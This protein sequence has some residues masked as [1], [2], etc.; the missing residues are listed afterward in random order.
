MFGQPDTTMGATPALDPSVGMP[1]P[2][3]AQC[4]VTQ[5]GGRLDLRNGFV[6]VLG[7]LL[8]GKRR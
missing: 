1:M 2:I 3:V 4:G 6:F 5:R 8:G 7:S